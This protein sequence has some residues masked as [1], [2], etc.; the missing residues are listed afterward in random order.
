MTEHRKGYAG[1][2]QT[3]PKTSKHTRKFTGPAARIK[4]VLVT[5]APWG[6]LPMAVADWRMLLGGQH[7]L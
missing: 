6:L 2:L 3:T 7:D 4:A 1:S 5:L